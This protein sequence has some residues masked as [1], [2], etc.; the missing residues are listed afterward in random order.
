MVLFGFS[1]T[2][3]SVIGAY[4]V[5]HATFLY[6]Q[7]PP[8][9]DSGGSAST[10]SSTPTAGNG[11]AMGGSESRGDVELPEQQ[12]LLKSE[13]TPSPRHS[14]RGQTAATTLPR[15]SGNNTVL[16]ERDAVPV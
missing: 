2:F 10:S 13:A 15:K 4:F 5:L 6:S 9:N 3:L 16:R 1:V 14:G 11:S 7:K 12:S 8:G